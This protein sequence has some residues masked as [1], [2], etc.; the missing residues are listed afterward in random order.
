MKTPT[1]DQTKSVILFLF[2]LTG[3]AYQQLTGQVN[4]LLLGVFTLMAGIIP[5]VQAVARLV[6]SDTTSDSSSAASVSSR[7]E[8]STS[9]GV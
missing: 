9:S 2:G 6:R 7:P 3:I 5:G 8:S 1:W 4:E